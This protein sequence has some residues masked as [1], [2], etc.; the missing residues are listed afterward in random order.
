MT[1]YEDKT[2]VGGASHMTGDATGD[3]AGLFSY[4]SQATPPGTKQ[5][6]SRTTR[7]ASLVNN[8]T[9]PAQWVSRLD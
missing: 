3:E 4:T 9:Q 6:C 7:G 2:F 1:G 8:K 5:S